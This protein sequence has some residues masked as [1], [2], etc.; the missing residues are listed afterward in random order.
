MKP[1]QAFLLLRE[2]VGFKDAAHVDLK[3]FQWEL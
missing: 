3:H 1:E 2:G